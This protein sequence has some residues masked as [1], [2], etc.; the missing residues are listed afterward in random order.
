MVQVF[1]RTVNS[2]ALYIYDGPITGDPAF[3]LT[4][5][6]KTAPVI[7][8]TDNTISLEYIT[9]SDL[10]FNLNDFQLVY[11]SFNDST[12]GCDGFI[13]GDS[14]KYCT[15]QQLHCDGWTHCSDGSDEED[16]AIYDDTTIEKLTFYNMYIWK[17]ISGEP[18][19]RTFT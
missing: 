19:K 10:G 13:C 6:N 16:C 11:T 4:C 17:A 1:A 2:Q 18:Y 9:A 14:N 12:N 3:K 5:A 7:Y 15:S 8:S